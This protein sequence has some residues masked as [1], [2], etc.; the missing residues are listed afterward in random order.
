MPRPINQLKQIRFL[1][2]ADTALKHVLKQWPK[3]NHP[4]TQKKIQPIKLQ[5]IKRYQTGHIFQNEPSNSRNT[6]ISGLA[7]CVT[8]VVHQMGLFMEPHSKSPW[9]KHLKFSTVWQYNYAHQ[10]DVNYHLCPRA[11][12]ACLQKG[13]LYKS[14]SSGYEKTTNAARERTL[15]K[16]HFILQAWAKDSNTDASMFLHKHI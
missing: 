1:A 6:D 10:M 12:R 7:A 5:W 15:E 8:L 16:S 4:T 2:L 14:L 9:W 13:S 3:P 11:P